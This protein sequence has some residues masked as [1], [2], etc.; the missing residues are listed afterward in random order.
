MNIQPESLDFF[1]RILETPSPSGYEQPVQR[2][3]REFASRFAD[4]VSTDVHG[5]VIA[6]RNPGAPLRVMLAGH[7]DQIGF[8]VHYIDSEGYLYVHPV[9]GWDPQIVVGQRMTVWTQGG[10]AFGVIARKP[11]HLLTEEERKQVVKLKDVWVDIGAKDQAQASS[12]VR[13]GD[14]VTLEL[15]FRGMLNERASSPSM[16][17]KTGL[18]VAME[19]LRRTQGQ[20]L[21]CA[22]Y[23]VSTVQEEIGLRGAKTSSFRIDPHVGVAVDVTHATDCP[24]VEKKVSG[25][26]ALDKGPVIFRGPNMNPRVADRLIE[27]AIKA[28]IPYQ[29]D[30]SGAAT[31]TD[32]NV[33]QINRAGVAAGLIGIPNRYMHS[34]VEMVSLN[35]LDHAAELLAQFAL[36]LTGAEDF[37]P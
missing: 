9:G 18:W 6:V 10:P 20:E 33:M 31:G 11:I 29:L 22:L 28:Q 23:A 25:D 19:A 16:D 14:P 5:N 8:L 17:D 7:A 36:A 13:I 24:T 15:G 21:K 1:K 27:A 4:E 35:D 34:P 2:L 26:V 37:T 3:V 30:A 12:L 32:A